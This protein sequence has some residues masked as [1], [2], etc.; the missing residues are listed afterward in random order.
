MAS[1]SDREKMSKW[2]EDNCKE[3]GWRIDSYLGSQSSIGH[4]DGKTVLNYSVYRYE[5]YLT[6][7]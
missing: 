4:R 2:I 6:N 1:H 5:Q 3:E 7:R